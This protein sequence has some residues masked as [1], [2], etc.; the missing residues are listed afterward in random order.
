[1]LA[2]IILPALLLAL[3]V[4]SWGQNSAVAQYNKGINYYNK[5]DYSN[6]IAC[7]KKAAEMGYPQAVALVGRSYYWSGNYSQAI[8]W[9]QKPAEQ[10]DE[11]AQLTLAYA[12]D[13]L[14]N[15]SKALPWFRTRRCFC[16]ILLRLISL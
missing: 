12:Y 15:H 5:K 14:K 2:R 16:A 8:S 6:A 13:G 11:D 3:S 4:C 7:F 1:M 10:G 9:L